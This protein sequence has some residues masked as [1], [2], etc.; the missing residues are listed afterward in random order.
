MMMESADFVQLLLE[1]VWIIGSGKGVV[2]LEVHHVA[3]VNAEHLITET[4]IHAITCALC[5]LLQN[6]TIEDRSHVQS[7]EKHMVEGS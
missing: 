6:H 4:R 5:E 3:N 2:L 7:P 1:K